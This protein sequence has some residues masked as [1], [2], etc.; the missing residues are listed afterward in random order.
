V[1]TAMLVIVRI[2]TDAYAHSLSNKRII[3]KLYFAI[4]REIMWQMWLYV[5]G[6]LREERMG[7]KEA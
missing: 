7:R 1:L 4:H 6:G 5:V 2:R 3:C